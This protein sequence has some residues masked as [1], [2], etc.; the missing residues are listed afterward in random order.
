L[1]IDV[2][3]LSVQLY[4]TS[5]F[6]TSIELFKNSS[7][8]EEKTN[9]LMFEELASRTLARRVTWLKKVYNI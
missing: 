2:N 5:S 6:Q 8:G 9:L 1:D 3:A 7:N 4:S